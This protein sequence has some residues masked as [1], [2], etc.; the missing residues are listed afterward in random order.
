MGSIT[1]VLTAHTTPGTEICALLTARYDMHA[2]ARCTPRGK[3]LWLAMLP[4]SNGAHL[5]AA[6]TAPDGRNVW[7][8]I[9]SKAQALPSG[10]AL[11]DIGVLQGPH[12]Q[13]AAVSAT[14][15][16]RWVPPRR[17]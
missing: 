12:A 4:T 8:L 2:T 17:A 6:Q 15:G 3:V 1:L 9:A 16:L 13:A 7:D 14:V 10:A 11:R 5:Q